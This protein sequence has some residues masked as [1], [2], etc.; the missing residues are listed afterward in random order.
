[1]KSLIL[2]IEKVLPDMS[3]NKF[4]YASIISSLYLGWEKTTR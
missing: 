3:L 4:S 1:M 2:S